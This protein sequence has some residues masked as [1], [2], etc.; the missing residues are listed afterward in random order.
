MLNKSLF[1]Y[2]NYVSLSAVRQANLPDIT[3]ISRS[4]V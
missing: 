2:I 3:K 4:S 1:N